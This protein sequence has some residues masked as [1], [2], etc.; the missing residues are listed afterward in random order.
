MGSKP[1]GEVTTNRGDFCPIKAIPQVDVVHYLS[2]ITASEQI[3]FRRLS[4]GTRGEPGH[5][6]E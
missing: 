4:Q 3:A 5:R 6:G 1:G 2:L